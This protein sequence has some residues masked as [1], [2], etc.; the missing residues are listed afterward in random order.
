MTRKRPD[1]RMEY[2]FGSDT[3]GFRNVRDDIA[4]SFDLLHYAA[5]T[6]TTLAEM[7]KI[8]IMEGERQAQTAADEK[9]AAAAVGAGI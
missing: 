4:V 8:L 6:A 2:H 7:R 3:R 1:G 9:A 5:G